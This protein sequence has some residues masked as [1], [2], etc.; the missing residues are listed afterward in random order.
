MILLQRAAP[1]RMAGDEV[2]EEPA[3]DRRVNAVD[4]LLVLPNLEDVEEVVVDGQL[5]FGAF[6]LCVACELPT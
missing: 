2:S 5:L 1:E 4:G 6:C 3:V